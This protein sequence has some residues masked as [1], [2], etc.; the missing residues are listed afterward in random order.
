MQE[1]VF[2]YPLCRIDGVNLACPRNAP[3]Q[4]AFQYPLCRIDGV[5]YAAS[6]P[7]GAKSLSVSALSDRWCEHIQVAHENLSLDFQYP[8]C[9]IDGVNQHKFDPCRVR[10][11]FQYPLCRIDGV[12]MPVG[13]LFHRT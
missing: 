11:H 7:A 3:V 1:L 4:V 10:R 6:V 2:Q 12:N 13:S 5:N 9:R 8:L